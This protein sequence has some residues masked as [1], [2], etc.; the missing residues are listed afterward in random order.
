LGEEGAGQA[1]GVA[2]Q[3]GATMDGRGDVEVDGHGS[4]SLLEAAIRE[5]MIECKNAVDAQP[6][7]PL[8]ARS[9][10]QTEIT[11]ISR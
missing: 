4:G 2:A 11:L 8:D 9:I 7:H 5:M 10:Y 6:P 1:F 3:A